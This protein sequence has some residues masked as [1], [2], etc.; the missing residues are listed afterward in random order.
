VQTHL[1][2]PAGTLTDKIR[3]IFVP[4]LFVSAFTIIGYSFL[5]WLILE[6]V[7][8]FRIDEEVV[9]LW[10]PAALIFAVVV[11]SVRPRIAALQ[12]QQKTR[13]PLFY[14][15]VAGMVMGFP[16][17]IAQQWVSQAAG[18]MTSTEMANKIVQ[19]PKTKYYS[20]AL[21][22]VDKQRTT[23]YTSTSFQGKDNETLQLACYFVCPFRSL[24][25]E[26]PVWLGT[27]YKK[28][29][30][31]Q[32]SDAQRGAAIRNFQIEAYRHYAAENFANST[33]FSRAPKN[34]D[35]RGFE[36]ALAEN[37]FYQKNG[38]EILLLAHNDDFSKR[39]GHELA[40]VFGSF[41]IGAALWFLL[42]FF[43]PIDVEAAT[44]R[45][46]SD[47]R[48][49]LLSEGNFLIPRRGFAATPILVDVNI[50]VFIGMVLAGF[51][52]TSVSPH[53]L[54]L[55]GG[56]FRPA[57]MHGQLWRLITSVFIHAGLIHLIGNLGSLVFAGIFLERLMG[58]LR[59]ITCYLICG[60]AG[61]LVSAAYHPATVA[62]GASGAIFGIWGV[63]LVIG[64]VK[65]NYTHV[66]FKSVAAIALFTIGYNLLLGLR[67]PGIDNAAHLGGLAAGVIVGL[68]VCSFPKLFLAD[69][70]SPQTGPWE[71]QRATFPTSKL[72]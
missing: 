51:G 11:I 17:M 61:A 14:C 32:L 39:T 66:P 2:R 43:V 53:D 48:Q 46:P 55:V 21:I 59:F 9:D 33:Y 69:L 25:G 54:L 35:L 34:S 60:I 52:V 58:S 62:V 47:L 40:W 26:N 70:K 67:S 50:L 3:F 30:S 65:S 27:V 18:G 45:K 56:N 10:L 44:T 63:L 36:A 22:Q 12:F 19:L 20:F 68:A 4:F 71:K 6:E 28:S 24:A 8:L 42:L 72:R 49:A 41:G 31:S 1:T 16:L 38:P 15:L 7:S 64:L 13:A 57:L 37:P 23:R 5:N 29:V